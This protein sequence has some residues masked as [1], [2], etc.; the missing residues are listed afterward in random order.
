MND[1]DIL[2]ANVEVVGVGEDGC[3]H[4]TVKLGASGRKAAAGFLAPTATLVIYRSPPRVSLH[5]TMF[6]KLFV[7]RLTSI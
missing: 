7:E 1:I 5:S 4:W 2:F 3:C 6:V